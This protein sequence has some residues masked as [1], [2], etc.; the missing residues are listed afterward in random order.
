VRIAARRR[1]ALRRLSALTVGLAVSIAGLLVTPAAGAS[2]QVNTTA[3]VSRPAYITAAEYF[4]Q[5]N[6][7]DLW[8]SDLSGAPTAFAQM[9]SEGVNTIGLV[10][11][12]DE[13]ET[14]VV[15]PRYNEAM[16]RRLNQL[17][18]DATRLGMGVILRLSYEWGQDLHDQMAELARFDAVWSNA[19]VYS[20]WLDYIGAVHADV[21]RF[22]NIREEYISWEDLWQPIYEA[23]AA[24]S[25]AKQLAAAT[26]TGYRSWLRSGHSLTQVSAAYGTT[27]S[28]WSDVPTPPADQPDFDLMYQYEDWALVHRLFIP[29]S[30]RFPG[31]SMETR[32]DVDPIYNGSQVVGS[33]THST[34]YQLPG[35]PVTGM[36]FSPYM[37]D[38]SPTLVET[39][40]DALSALGSVL[41]K[42]HSA[43]SQPLFIYEYE[44]ESNSPQVSDDPALAPT[45]IPAFIAQSE[46]LLHEYTTG[47]ALW[48][49]RDY[50]QSPVYNQSFAL[51]PSGWH[52]S[53]NARTVA[54]P[55]STSYA[56]LGRGASVSQTLPSG[57]VNNAAP[58]TVSL[59]ARAPRSTNLLLAW[60]GARGAG[61][62]E[63]AVHVTPG[64]HDYQIQIPATS[65]H[66]LS[67]KAASAAAVTDI[68]MYWYTQLGDIYSNTG[69]PEVG[70]APLRLLNQQLTAAQG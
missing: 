56:S 15:P 62:K 29:A 27:F 36:Y 6:P 3:A 10:V 69:A 14:S 40:S 8:S 61:K 63:V 21:A 50:N 51:G 49:Y 7:I 46:P 67:I 20:A 48:T 52:L 12:W 53:R 64:W 54:R 43:T 5:S 47:Y 19:K 66:T 35:A 26:A 33:F 34:Q 24:T 65:G 4:G 22:G 57:T 18:S 25:P 39:A 28:S 13:F 68:Q 44:I 70:A 2:S 17:I 45:Q 55:T 9:K 37:N 38:P 60:S 32:V 42:M 16:F 31:L 23:Q 41:A 59:E 58:A 30:K 1:T 11:P